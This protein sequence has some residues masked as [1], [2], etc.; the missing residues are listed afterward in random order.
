M[1]GEPLK[2][3]PACIPPT[4]EIESHLADSGH[5][6]WDPERPAFPEGESCRMVCFGMIP[7]SHLKILE[8]SRSSGSMR[9][10]ILSMAK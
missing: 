7:E 3:N 4:I 8:V 9:L 5:N 6:V 1:E 10:G 2:T